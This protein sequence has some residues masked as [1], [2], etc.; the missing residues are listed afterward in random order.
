MKIKILHLYPKEMNLYGDRGNILALEKRATWRGIK[1]EVVPYEPG[2]K[3][4]SDINLIFGGG[5]QDSSQS[6]IEKD[7]QKI[8][9]RLKELIEN[10]VPALTI[11]GLYQ[12]FGNFFETKDGDRIEGTHILN[13]STKAG[14]ERLIGNIVIDSLEFGEIVGYENH[15]GLTSLG[16]G[17]VAFGNTIVGFGN[18][19]ED[20]TEGARYKNCIGTYLHGPI[21]PKNPAIAD[22]LIERALSFSAGKEIELEKL[23]DGI[24]AL[25]HESAVARA[26]TT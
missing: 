15:S 1:V 7:L 4:P 5:G 19:G 23:D 22:F 2:A 25:A 18:N 12:L 14:E 26:K 9:P 11:C 20:K 8:A 16:E 6:L 24:E 3:I 21:L 17:V 13:L 10:G